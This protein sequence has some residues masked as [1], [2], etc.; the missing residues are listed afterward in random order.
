MKVILLSL[1]FFVMSGG[2]F[3]QT[4]IG[5]ARNASVGSTVTVTGVV[6]NGGEL[7]TIRYIQ[8]NTGGIGVYDYN[9][10]SVINRGDSITVT[11]E[12]DE[13]N[14]LMEIKDITNITSHAS[15]VTLPAPQVISVSQIGEDYEGELIRINNV[16]ITG[17]DGTFVGNTNYTFTDGTNTAEL[18]VNSNSSLVGEAIPSGKFNLVA[19]CSQYSYSDANSGYQLLPRDADDIMSDGGINITSSVKMIDVSKNSITLGWGT[20]TIGSAYVRYGSSNS[21]S[22]LTN[23]NEGSSSTF[24][25][26]SNHVA[27]ITGLEPAEI[28]YAQAFNVCGADTAFASIQAFITNS[29][30][31]GDIRVY[32][33]TEVDE[34]K[35]TTTTAQYIG[36]AMADTLG[37]YIDRANISI[38]FCIYNF[39]NSTVAN[40]L[41]DAYNRGV[42][43]RFITCGSTAHSSVNLLNKN[44]LVLEREDADD[45]IMHNKFAIFDANSSNPDEAWVWSGSTNLTNQ[46]LTDDVNNMIFIQDQSLAKVYKIEFEE[47][48]GS[49]DDQPDS[50]KSKFGADKS[51]NTPHYVFVGDTWI[52][53]YF[54]PSDNTNQEI[55]EAIESSDNDL[56]VETMLI[57]KSDIAQ[58]II[59]AY[60]NGVDVSVMTESESDNTE[61]VNN[62]L[63]GTLPSDKYVFDDDNNRTLHS[64]VAIIDAYDTGSDPQL[65]TGSHNWSNSANTRNDENTLIIHSA[66]IANQYFQQFASCFNENGGGL[67]VS[68]Q[69]IEVADVRVYPNPTQ[70]NI[71]VSSSVELQK[72]EL[73]S[74][75]G[76]LVKIEYPQYN[77]S[78][79]INMGRQKSGIYILR[80]ESLYGTTNTYK[81][82]KSK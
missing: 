38:D 47:M 54:S 22:A 62:I 42:V 80:V 33:N 44:I 77:N 20:D 12:L 28:V 57:T 11:G 50:Y 40:A 60:G 73:Y 10:A 6:T 18:R 46:Q 24:G 79:S 30:S 56:E 9:N 2:L 74:V 15:N 29:N 16:K 26:E 13:Y 25:G 68:S 21:E 37:A 23:Y 67:T 58:A 81:V 41:N 70:N 27:E 39:I 32:F 76:K 72:V 63:S 69:S 45:G 19:I 78:V 7:G 8:D 43:V 61:T 59:E 35:A 55:I 48:W 82:V 4:T 31:A 1:L 14:S 5:E 49:I 51:D 71:N 75:H 34:T 3:A 64:K 52:E 53:C 36:D 66:D 17:S 65:I